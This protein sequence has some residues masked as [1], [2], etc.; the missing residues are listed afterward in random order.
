MEKHQPFLQFVKPIAKAIWE[1]MEL[2]TSDVEL[3]IG[4]IPPSPSIPSCFLLSLWRLVTGAPK[5]I[6]NLAEFFS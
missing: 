1:K 2:L 4:V 6:I 3:F 5:R